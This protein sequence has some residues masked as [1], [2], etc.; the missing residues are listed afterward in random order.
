MHQINTESHGARCSSLGSQNGGEQSKALAGAR[1][2]KTFGNVDRLG[3]LHRDREGVPNGAGASG[4]RHQKKKA[5]DEL[6]KG[7]PFL[8]HFIGQLSRD[9]GAVTM[10]GGHLLTLTE[11]VTTER[12][13]KQDGLAEGPG[14]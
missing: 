2:M 14:R 13:Q 7:Q 6:R 9:H 5:V 10:D 3:I 1:S 11:A 8:R 12:R 4:L